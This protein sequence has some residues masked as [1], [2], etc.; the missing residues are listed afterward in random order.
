MTTSVFDRINE[1]GVL[2]VLGCDPDELQILFLTEAGIIGAAGGVAGVLLSYG[3]KGI[4]D[5]IAVKMF[6]LAKGTQ[7][8]MIPWELAAGA[9]VGA[10]LLAICAGYFPARFASKL[11]PLDAVRNR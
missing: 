4:V 7:I 2:K 8:A 9:V 1:I 6:D 5:K 3:V 11:Q 10:I